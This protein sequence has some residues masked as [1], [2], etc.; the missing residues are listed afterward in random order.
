L[1]QILFISITQT[2]ECIVGP[3]VL[4]SDCICCSV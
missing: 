1:V 4:V 2:W 3:D